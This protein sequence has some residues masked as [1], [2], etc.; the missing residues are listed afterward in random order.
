MDEESQ[1]R[2]NNALY[3]NARNR[4]L[5]NLIRGGLTSTPIGWIFLGTVVLISVIVFVIVLGGAGQASETQPTTATQNINNFINI[6]GASS[7]Q[8]QII[9]DSLNLA[10]SYPLYKKLL[11]D[12]GIVNVSFVSSLP[13]PYENADAVVLS[14]DEIKIRGG[15][16]NEKLKYFFLH[17]TGHIIIFRNGAVFSSYRTFFPDLIKSDSSCY[18]PLSKLISYPFAYTR[19]GGEA[20]VESFA[21]SI[22]QFLIYNEKFG[23]KDFPTKCPETYGWF[24]ENVFLGKTT[25]EDL[26]L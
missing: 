21:E 6:T 7:S 12:R 18:S 24:L 15:I 23:L 2:Q 17:E 25:T 9:T 13:G 11:T 20:D 19:G 1:K 10:L 16:Q 4:V 8:A 14:K 22:S 26:R 5:A 3:E